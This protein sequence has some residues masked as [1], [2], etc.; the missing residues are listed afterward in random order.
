MRKI[1]DFAIIS[2]S[3]IPWFLLAGS[4]SGAASG[5]G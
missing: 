1:S 5:G 3:D 2:L 4:P